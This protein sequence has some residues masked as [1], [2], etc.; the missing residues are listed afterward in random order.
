MELLYK[1]EENVPI[2]SFF[3][4]RVKEPVLD[5]NWHFHE[6]YEIIHIIKGQGVRLVGDNLSSF[7]SGELV[8]VGPNVPHLWRTMKNVE[9]VDRIIIKFDEL[10]GGLN[11]F[12]I[13]EFS[14]IKSLLKTAETGISFGKETREKVQKFI[15]ELSISTGINK[16]ICMLN[17]LNILAASRDKELLSSPYM[18]ISPNNPEENR[19]SKVISYISENYNK[20][21]VLDDVADIASMTIQSFCRFFKKR[22][23]KTFVQFLNEYRI[24]KA[25]VLL[26]EDRMS[27]S[28]ICY[29][30][31]YNSTTNFNRVFKRQYSCTPVEYRKKYA[32][33]GNN[34][35]LV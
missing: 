15:I 2:D 32:E 21:I 22:T 5:I 6:E 35:V 11:L 33:V 12:S 25:C 9:S 28:E 10:P 29:D 16:W 1:K 18:K 24:G 14:N 8:L 19:L 26:V 23:N 20:D 17:I 7:G 4:K 13:P 27:V 3:V 34:S 30:L 31:G